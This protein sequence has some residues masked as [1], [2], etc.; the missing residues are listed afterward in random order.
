MDPGSDIERRVLEVLQDV[1][2]LETLPAR[3]A[4]L[5][6]ELLLSSMD[7][8][9]LVLTL[10]DEFGGSIAEEEM[11]TIDTVA[12]LISFIEQRSA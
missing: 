2:A 6:V 8:M 3:G 12:D 7:G 5:R 4:H 1:L 11:A 9:A 10:E